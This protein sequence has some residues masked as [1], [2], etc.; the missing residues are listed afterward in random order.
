MATN[1]GLLLR[2]E[3]AL[4]NLREFVALPG[5]KVAAFL[6]LFGQA[7]AAELATTF[8]LEAVPAAA[9]IRR[10]RC[11]EGGWDTA[12]TIFPFLVRAP[13]SLRPLQRHKTEQVYRALRLADA[14]NGE[15]RFQLASW[16]HVERV[17]GSRSARYGSVPLF[18]CWSLPAQTTRPQPNRHYDRHSPPSSGSVNSLRSV[19]TPIA[20][21]CKWMNTIGMQ[22]AKFERCLPVAK[23][24]LLKKSVLVPSITR[25]AEVLSCRNIEAP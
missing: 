25:P 4:S 1:F 10:P 8:G 21:A 24:D 5:L 12:Q 22:E 9:L 2:W 15:P 19:A 16:L 13:S 18:R 20:P 11:E 14:N 7:I 17:K 3:A 6:R 23:M